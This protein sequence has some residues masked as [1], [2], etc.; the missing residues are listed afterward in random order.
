MSM[1]ARG[2]ARVYRFEAIVQEENEFVRDCQRG[3]AEAWENLVRRHWRHIY[4][5]CRRFTGRVAESHDL[6]Q[7][8]LLRVFRTLK[9]FRADDL[10]FGAWL[11][12]VTRNLLIDHYRRS[13]MERAAVP[14]D[15]GEGRLR[16]AGA[17]HPGRSYERAEMRGHLRSAM[18]ALPEDVRAAVVL[19]DV[20]GL[21]YLEIARRLRVPVGTVKSRLN[22]GRGLLAHSLRKKGIAA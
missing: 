6:T 17:E 14:L 21:S 15:S 11:N 19:C 1:E 5:M 20:E 9:T 16:L 2:P 18:A 22:R 13:R 8:V 3:D 10:S 7:E 4:A 12:L